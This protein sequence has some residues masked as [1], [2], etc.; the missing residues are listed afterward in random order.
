MERNYEKLLP[1]QPP[2]GALE[3]MLAEGAFDRQYL[4]YR[5]EWYRDPLTNERV[6]GVRVNCTKCGDSAIESYEPGP[7]CSAYAPAPFGFYN[8][9]WQEA[10]ISG[11]DTLCPLCGGKV[12]ARH[13][14]SMPNGIQDEAW[15]MTVGRVE[16]KL[17][18]FGWLFRRF[19]DKEGKSEFSS[20]PYEA[21]VVE[22]KKIVRLM[23][24]RKCLS[25]VQLFGHW[26]QRKQ[27]LDNWGM[28]PRIMPWPKELLEGTAAEN[29][30]LDRYLK[31]ANGEP[32]PVTYLKFW[33]K[34]PQVENLIVQ[35]AG[36]IVAELIKK[37]AARYSYERPKAC[38]EIKEIDWKEKRPAQMLGLNR[39]ELR[40]L[41]KEKWT[42]KEW[43]FYKT[44]RAEEPFRL[45]EDMETVRKV[46][47]YS[48]ETLLRMKT[49]RGGASVMRC[50]WYLLRQAQRQEKGAAKVDAGYLRDY[51]NMAAGL[52]EDLGDP[53]LRFPKDLVRAHDRVMVE[54]GRIAAEKEEKERAVEIA[55]RAA[56]F[57]ARSEQ[58]APYSWEND[59][60]TIRP[61]KDERELIYEGKTLSHCVARYAASVANGRTAIF[62]IRKKN[63][64][65]K[66]WFTLELDEKTLTVR[67]NRGKCNCARTKAVEVFEAAW[68]A[69]LKTLRKAGK[70]DNIETSAKK[71][72]KK[73]ERIA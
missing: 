57:A 27:Y 1:T 5:V 35:G 66:P 71:R 17:V 56:E 2:K 51:W 6:K 25:T 14:G 31:A 44:I 59:G 65:D 62:L 13:I 40:C 19:I 54:A 38:P 37:G 67:Q 46:G 9:R 10:V 16:D 43:A 36:K 61:V 26:E 34:R 7:N 11:Q 12:T 69:R 68:L 4:V 47:I 49:V 52:G 72:K 50:V 58:L 70:L 55:K 32:Y 24:Y 63:E 15:C 39:D 3:W 22:E 73:E 48:A 20:L 29:S 42:E 8:S 45:P 21:Y 30:K 60:I 53:S 64:P 28:A 33:Q 41:V 18:L 23:G